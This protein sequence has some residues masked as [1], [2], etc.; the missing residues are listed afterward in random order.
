METIPTLTPRVR[1]GERRQQA[2][3][4]EGLPVEV[5]TKQKTGRVSIDNARIHD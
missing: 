1:V 2:L 4:G 5:V 3:Y